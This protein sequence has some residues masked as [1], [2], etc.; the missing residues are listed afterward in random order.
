MPE[1]TID[2]ARADS[3]KVSAPSEAEPHAGT[4]MVW[5][6]T[7]AVYGGPGAYYESV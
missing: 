6:S 1:I 4:W 2:T 3:W 7:S 5:P